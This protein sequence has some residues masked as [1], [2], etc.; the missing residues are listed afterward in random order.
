[1]ILSPAQP[2]QFWV[3]GSQTFN[4]KVVDGINSKCWCQPFNCDDEVIVQFR[5]ETGGSYNLIIQDETEDVK[6][7]IAFDEVSEGVYQAS[8]NA[9]D[10]NFCNDDVQL[11][12][13][14]GSVLAQ[15][16]CIS[17][18]TSHPETV[19]IEYSNNRNYF[20][21]TYEDVSPALSFF[22]RVP[23]VF[24]HERFP[25]EDRAMERTSSTIITSSKLKK[26]RLMQILHA[27][28]YFHETIILALTHQNVTIDGKTWRKE[29]PYEKEDGDLRYPLKRATVYLTE[30]NFLARNVL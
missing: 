7:T 25:Q 24:F 17:F 11:L 9:E 22:L 26:Q 16:D 18:R 15:S 19:L 21:L 29:E 1:M 30:K 4:E 27:P 2:V 20:G 8:F 28:N 14:D 3:T 5:E 12:I 23:A 10:E 13:S 6:A